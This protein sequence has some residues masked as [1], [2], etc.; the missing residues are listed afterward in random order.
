[1]AMRGRKMIMERREKHNKPIFMLQLLTQLRTSLC[2]FPDRHWFYTTILRS[3]WYSSHI[4]N[5]KEGIW[6]VIGW[7]FL[8]CHICFGIF[9]CSIQEVVFTSW[10]VHGSSTWAF[11]QKAR[12]LNLQWW[13][14]GEVWSCVR[15]LGSDPHP[16]N[17]PRTEIF[18]H[19]M[20]TCR[21]SQCYWA[22]CK[23]KSGM[24]ICSEVPTT[25][26]YMESYLSP[27]LIV[28]KHW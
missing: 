6:C 1:M 15:G 23:C 4:C 7:V 18:G 5:K 25:V 28:E 22:F 9:S 24:L 16:G 14:V 20:S 11:S 17:L 2:Q 26:W 10:Y 19:G 12:M 21:L 13:G 8:S 27:L 3:P